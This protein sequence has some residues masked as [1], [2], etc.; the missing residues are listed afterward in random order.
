METIEEK[1]HSKTF[2]TL[3]ALRQ[4]VS[5]LVS[6]TESEELLAEAVAV[7][8]GMPLPCA[9]THEQMES[10][11]REAEADYQNRRYVSHSSVCERY[12]V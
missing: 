12:G 8:S 9:Y 5:M 1:K 4:R 6:P 10:V 7:L 2:D 11:L 3:V